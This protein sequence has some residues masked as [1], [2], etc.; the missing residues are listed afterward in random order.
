M[1]RTLRGCQP[2]AKRGGLAATQTSDCEINP[3]L[4]FFLL[5]N[6]TIFDLAF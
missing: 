5:P 3:F 2:P 4:R 1:L 6:Q